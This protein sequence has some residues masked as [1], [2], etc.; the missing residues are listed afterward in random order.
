MPLS[1]TMTRWTSRGDAA[2]FVAFIGVDP[3][4]FDVGRRCAS[5]KCAHAPYTGQA[6]VDA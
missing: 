5:D 2:N 4:F 6:V 1:A 3:E